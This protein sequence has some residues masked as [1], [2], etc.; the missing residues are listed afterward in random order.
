MTSEMEIEYVPTPVE[1]VIKGK[2]KRKTGFTQDEVAE[3]FMYDIKAYSSTKN[4]VSDPPV[5]MHYDTV[6][7]I[8]TKESLII[9]NR[10]CWSAGFAY[11]SL[12]PK[13]DLY[14]DLTSLRDLLGMDAKDLASM[15]ML[16]KDENSVLLRIPVLVFNWAKETFEYKGD[17]YV[18]NELGNFIAALAE[19]CKTVKEAYESMMPD[20]VKDARAKGIEI[21][22]QGEW[23][24]TPFAKDP[25]LIEDVKSIEKEWYVD[26]FSKC[27]ICGKVAERL[28]YACYMHAET[29]DRVEVKR[30]RLKFPGLEEGSSHVAR[31]VGKY[32]GHIVVLG[33]IRHVDRDHEIL[34]IK[35]WYYALRNVVR[36]AVSTRTRRGD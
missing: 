6:Q 27:P 15:D 11:C 35:G 14:L 36:K 19:P 13:V 23:F 21:H 20:M 3:L 10:Q 24:F 4:F 8:K 7:A 22:R 32:K 18:L 33:P 5:L 1:A 9:A 30:Y 12:P 31:K 25:K 16:D 2:S 29:F 26:I 34:R 17:E 28:P